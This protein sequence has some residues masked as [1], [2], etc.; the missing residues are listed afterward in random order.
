MRNTCVLNL[1]ACCRYSSRNVSYK[2]GAAL[3]LTSGA[4]R[5]LGIR[6]CVS[7]HDDAHKGTKFLFKTKSQLIKGQAPQQKIG[8][9]LMPKKVGQAQLVA[10]RCCR[11]FYRKKD[12]S[13]LFDS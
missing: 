2:M 7:P 8:R 9:G 4:C 12:V 11:Q 1:L 13:S 10:N 5:R 3:L 6:S